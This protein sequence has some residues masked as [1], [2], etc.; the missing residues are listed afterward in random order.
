MRRPWAGRTVPNEVVI[1]RASAQHISQTRAAFEA[2]G[3][4]RS[5]FWQ[6]EV[7]TNGAA[8]SP[9]NQAL[10]RQGNAPFGTDGREMVLHH[11]LPIEWGGTNDFCNLRIMRWSDHA[12]RPHFGPLHTPPFDII[13]NWR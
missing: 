10:M 2:P 12:L 5:Q 7:A 8:Y 9:R 4:V 3:G 6:N 1:Q 11:Q 13:W